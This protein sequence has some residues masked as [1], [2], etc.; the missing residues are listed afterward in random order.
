MNIKF[1]SGIGIILVLSGLSRA[2]K[3]PSCNEE[4]AYSGFCLAGIPNFTYD[5]KTKECREFIYGGCGGNRNR[6]ITKKQCE[7]MCVE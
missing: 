2:Q 4:T 3:D 1:I 7:D 6:F 5:P